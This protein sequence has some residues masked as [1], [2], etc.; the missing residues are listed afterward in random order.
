MTRNVRD[1]AMLLQIL[2]GHDPKDPGSVKI[3][4]PNYASA[5][6]RDLKGLRVG[7]V[8]HFY[9][10]DATADPEQIAAIDKAAETLRQLGAEVREVRLAPAAEYETCCRIILASEAYAI[11]RKWLREQPQNYGE[12]GR[13]RLL[14]GAAYTAAD[15]ID[16]LRMRTRLTA[17]TLAV[18]ETID[19]ALTSSSLD[20]PCI[21]DDAETVARTYPRQSRQ[22]FNV[23]GQPAL[24]MCAGFTRGGLPLSL[25]LI[26][27]PFEE[28]TV[29]Q[30]AHAYEEATGW[31][32]QH[33]PGV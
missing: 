5:L 22:P 19:V 6:K 29:Y 27:R 10:G 15:Y 20:P 11:H 32:K 21:L 3:D 13:Q 17:Q 7:L 25:Q 12:L 14:A 33:P 28:T 30:V 18:F 2:A 26:G 24:A 9:D 4:L 8:R 16:A 1:N 23:T 31:T